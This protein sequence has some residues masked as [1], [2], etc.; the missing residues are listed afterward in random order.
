MTSF[1]LNSYQALTEDSTDYIADLL[2]DVFSSTDNGSFP[3]TPLRRRGEGFTTPTSVKVVNVLWF[4]SLAITLSVALL[5]I[6]AKQWL[7]EYERV[8]LSSAPTAQIWSRRQAYYHQGLEEWGVPVLVSILPTLLHIALFLFLSGLALFL[9]PF[10]SNSAIV[11]SV[12]SCSV[13][14][15]YVV[16]M[17]L[18]IFSPSCAWRTPLSREIS[19]TM[20]P[21]LGPRV[22]ACVAIWFI[23]IGCARIFAISALGKAMAASRC[24]LKSAI[25]RYRSLVSFA[26][27]TAVRV[28]FSSALI[29]R[30]L[31]LF[32]AQAGRSH[33]HHDRLA[34]LL[35]ELGSFMRNGP[36][37]VRSLVNFRRRLGRAI[38]AH[39]LQL[40]RTIDAHTLRLKQ[41]IDAHT[42]VMHEKQ[43]IILHQGHFDA[44]VLNW[45]FG[46]YSTRNVTAVAVQ[47]IG[48]VYPSTSAGEALRKINS[49]SLKA[50]VRSRSLELDEHD[51]HCSASAKKERVHCIRAWIFQ[52]LG[53]EES[54]IPFSDVLSKDRRDDAFLFNA[55]TAHYDAFTGE[56]ATGLNGALQELAIRAN[57]KDQVPLSTFLW[58]FDVVSLW[59]PPYEARKSDRGP[60][61]SRVARL[62]TESSILLQL[63]LL[64]GPMHLS[65]NYDLITRGITR[66]AQS[67]R[68][69]WDEFYYRP[70]LPLGNF[71]SMP[72]DFFF[73]GTWMRFIS[74]VHMLHFDDA[75]KRAV[76]LHTIAC[77]K[78]ATG[79]YK[80][81]AKVFHKD[82][83]DPR[84]P[85]GSTRL[86][87]LA[88]DLVCDYDWSQD[89]IQTLL[90]LLDA[91][92]PAQSLKEHAMRMCVYVQFLRV[93]QPHANVIAGGLSDLCDELWDLCSKLLSKIMELILSRSRA[94]DPVLRRTDGVEVMP[95]RDDLDHCI[96]SFARL[97]RER[98]AT[99]VVSF[100]DEQRKRDGLHRKIALRWLN[101]VAG[102]V[103]VHLEFC[104]RVSYGSELLDALAR[105]RHDFDFDWISKETEVAIPLSILEQLGCRPSAG[106]KSDEAYAQH[107]L[108][109]PATTA[110][111][112]G[113]IP[114]ATLCS[115]VNE[116]QSEERAAMGERRKH[117]HQAAIHATPTDSETEQLIAYLRSPA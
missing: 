77:V 4:S 27:N 44:R 28:Y 111:D 18:P 110:A 91:L 78:A 105:Y 85:A 2:F 43:D 95:G 51:L 20:T 94:Q 60:L 39:A 3:T 97:S 92:P 40:K 11:V 24:F 26:R 34:P 84:I 12:I 9:L 113:T 47:A 15:F 59:E 37:L 81:F 96:A 54:P 22:G 76:Q 31:P 38:H 17:V 108:Y 82:P 16:Q 87:F 19:R 99:M 71:S 48:S 5:C 106:K 107:G 116:L 64:I 42:P 6:L 112:F 30:S 52:T 46:Q 100:M 56:P 55:L 75:T 115:K 103:R 70:F 65:A 68:A 62:Q 90:R 80:T 36:P 109:F 21:I 114:H 50:Y 53:R 1:L 35:H 66:W 61:A 93:V 49:T 88:S 86:G 74:F 29:T 102:R 104:S 7:S 32:T 101:I 117:D 23:S 72:A 14:A 79:L 98:T 33:W 25:L 58:I 13:A 8:V 41:T 73:F 67:N 57:L 45:L 69:E 10:D 83:N 63:M 89:E